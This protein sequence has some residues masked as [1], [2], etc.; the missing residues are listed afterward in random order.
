MGTRRGAKGEPDRI[1]RPDLPAAVGRDGAGSDDQY[2]LRFIQ[3][4]QA[5]KQYR[6]PGCN[7]EIPA[8]TGHLVVVPRD[9]PELRRHWHTPCWQA[10]T[11][12]APRRPRG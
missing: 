11:R 1:R 8:R 5:L 4:Y 7:H 10:R 3:P 2:E 12:R 9:E 6:C